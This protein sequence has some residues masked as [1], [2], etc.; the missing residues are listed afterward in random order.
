MA[1]GQSARRSEQ[2]GGGTWHS[3]HEA[4]GAVL[5]LH[6]LSQSVS[7]TASVP[8]S[9]QGTLRPRGGEVPAP[10]AGIRT[11]AVGAST[12]EHSHQARLP[13]WHGSQ[14][15]A[16]KCHRKCWNTPP[17]CAFSPVEAL[18]DDH[19]AH[20]SACCASEGNSEQRAGML[21]WHVGS[22]PFPGVSCSCGTS[23]GNSGMVLL[24]CSSIPLMKIT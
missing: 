6:V 24:L 11:W 5:G 12:L 15:K 13:E 10:R 23:Q 3:A 9:P 14:G 2:A 4:P 7:S 21:H 1:S 20:V 17:S 8:S 18:D 22:E 16:V 19:L